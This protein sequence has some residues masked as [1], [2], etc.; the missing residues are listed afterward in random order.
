VNAVGGD[1]DF[2]NATEREQEPYEVCGRLFRGL[3]DNVTDG[4]GDR[5]LEHYSLGLEASKVHP[6][7]L[8]RLEHP[9]D[10]PTLPEVK[11]KRSTDSFLGT[12]SSGPSSSQPELI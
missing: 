9:K 1:F 7:A 11:R 5:S 2:A 4:I 8:A 12:N 3:F 6:H 10:H